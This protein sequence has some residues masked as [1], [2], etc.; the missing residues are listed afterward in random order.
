MLDI[1]L[2]HIFIRGSGLPGSWGDGT[3][4]HTWDA[5]EPRRV[6]LQKTVPV[7]RC[8]FIEVVVDRDFEPVAPVGLFDCQRT[9][10]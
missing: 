4:H 10:Y 9:S 8:T 7:E 5:I 2:F 6:F 1:L 3:L